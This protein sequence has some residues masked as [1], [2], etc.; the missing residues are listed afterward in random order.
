[1]T[2][3]K[4]KLNF[5]V[6][7]SNSFSG[8]H[9]IDYVLKKRHL[10]IGVSRSNEINSVFLPYKNNINKKLF[11]FYKFNLNN[12][13]GIRFIIKIIKKYKINLVVNFAAQAMVAES[14]EFPLD[15]YNTN[16][17]SQAELHFELLKIK[18]IKKYV[19]VS[20]PEVYGSTKSI[21]KENIN[22]NPS[23]PY[24]VSRAACDMHLMNL[25]KNYKF[26]VVFT[27]SANVYGPGQQLYRI[28]PKTILSSISN[29]NMQLHGGGISKRSFIYITDV[30]DATYKICLKAKSGE[31]YHISSNNVVKIKNLVKKIFILTNG[32]YKKFVKIGKERPGK[33]QLYFLNSNKLKKKIKWKSKISLD[34]GLKY[35]I[36]WIK[37]N[38][39]CLNNISD[40]Y[41]HKK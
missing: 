14:W 6:I 21:I 36:D 23:T 15:Y 24:A 10:T 28:V 4:N 33:D 39:K 41:K 22:Y 29:K 35:T 38:Y 26:P 17:L 20:T 27:R 18:N 8:S 7:G 1:M 31:I 9:F 16:I 3:F 40:I 32:S 2:N 12:K 13:N 25:F 5:L 30:A 19:H 11:K 34:N 37:K